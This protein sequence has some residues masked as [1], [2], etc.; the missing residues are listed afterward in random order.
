MRLLAAAVVAA[1]PVHGVLVP[2]RS[3]A[4]VHLGDSTAA[5]RARLGAGYGVCESCTATTWYFTYRR[6]TQQ[7]LGVEFRRGRV[8]AVFTLW[9]PAGWHASTGQRFGDPAPRGLA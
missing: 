1:L 2:G 9:E 7:G 6:F 5:V 8:A 4:G 3:L